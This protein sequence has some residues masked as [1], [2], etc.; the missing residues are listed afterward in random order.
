M[1]PDSNVTFVDFALSPEDL[2]FKDELEAFLDKEMPPFVETWAEAEDLDASRGVMGAMEKRKA[3]Q[4]KLNEGR[5]AA[6]LRGPAAMAARPASGGT[7]VAHQ[8]VDRQA[9]GHIGGDAGIAVRAAALEGQH[10]LGCR[11]GRARRPASG[12]TLR[13]AHRRRRLPDQAPRHR[14]RHR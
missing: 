4:H 7:A 2:V 13:Q 8:F 10:Q 3:W 11:H 1:D 12:R 5:W 9:K 14:W 6:I